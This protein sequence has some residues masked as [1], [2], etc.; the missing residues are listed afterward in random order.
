MGGWG[1]HW[2]LD[3]L[4]KLEQS[5]KIKIVSP[6]PEKKT[7]RA[8]YKNKK[9]E[10]DGKVFDSKKEYLRYRELEVLLKQGIIGLLECQVSYELNP[11]G[12]HSLSYI[13]DFRY[14]LAETGET[15]VEDTKGYKT[16]EYLKKRRLMKKVHGIMIKET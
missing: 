5:G 8:K 7:K 10:Y 6:L 9:V 4:K 13:A 15:I 3:D 11:G 1:K 16:R 12:T 2:T 14:V